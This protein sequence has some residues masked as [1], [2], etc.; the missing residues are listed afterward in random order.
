MENNNK[1][2]V[3]KFKK[4]ITQLPIEVSQNKGSDKIVFY[5]TN[6]LYPNFLLSLFENSPMHQGIISDKLYYILGDGIVE[7]ASGNKF[8]PMVNAVDNLEEL[9]NKIVIDYIIFGY[10][11]IEVMYNALGEPI[12]FVHVPASEV[13]SN[14]SA[15]MFQVCDD[16]FA[17]SRNVLSYDRWKKGKNEDGKSTLFFYK[18]Y[19][20]SIQKVYPKPE[21]HSS[22]KSL[23]TDLAIR[24]FHLNNIKNGFSVSSLITFY[25]ATLQPEMKAQFQKKIEEVYSGE[26]GAKF[27]ID[28][29]AKDATPANVQNISSNDWD[30]AYDLVRQCVNEDI[31]AAHSMPAI[32]YGQSQ[33]GK[34]GGSGS[35]FEMAYEKFKILYVKGKRNEIESGL[36]KLF[37][38][39]KYPEI[40]F[41]DKSTFF[42]TRIADTTKE[43]V[44]TID[45]LRAIDGLEPLPNG[46]GAM[47]IAS[48]VKPSEPIKFNIETPKEDKNIYHSLSAEDFE[49]V[50]DLGVSKADFE[51]VERSEAIENFSQLDNILNKFDDADSVNKYLLATDLNNK[52]ISEIRT[53]IKKEMAITITTAELGDKLQKLNTA[54]I[55]SIK[56]AG[57]VITQTPID[58]PKVDKA[59]DKTPKREVEVLY[60]YEGVK[61]DRNRAFCAKILETDRFYSRSEIQSMS[62]L[63]GYDIF[64]FRGG[65]YNNP[66]TG[67][68]QPFCRH[69]WFANQVIKKGDNQ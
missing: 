40:E 8:N 27:I 5:G 57:G 4:H 7:K 29:V 28:Y 25:G 65:W 47:L 6:N 17:N 46:A 44:L 26:S 2:E 49:K 21:Y 33:E 56:I 39:A 62:S 20:P 3:V 37:A 19:N 13:R 18:K 61:D 51:I 23:E 31:L 38:D 14:R 60:S 45:E 55:I 12:E 36:N 9:V 54:G 69:R 63:F 64:K 48:I 41:K 15:E 10:F 35:E 50:K 30:K 1:P 66:S 52:S 68:N 16:W 32:L 11:S 58:K 67:E 22:I 34:M 59:T 42:S 53:E 24:D 43:K